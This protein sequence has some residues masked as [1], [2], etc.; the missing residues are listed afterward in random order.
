MTFLFEGILEFG[1][2]DSSTF[3]LSLSYTYM[4]YIHNTGQIEICIKARDSLMDTH[5][6]L[7]EQSVIYVMIA[8]TH[9]QHMDTRKVSAIEVQFACAY[10]L[11]RGNCSLHISILFVLNQICS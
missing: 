11:E 6:Q 10:H 5:N 7:E 2:T 3:A 9:T 4:L 1:V 8:L